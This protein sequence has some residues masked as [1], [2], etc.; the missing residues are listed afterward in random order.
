MESFSLAWR[1]LT[2]LP[3][4]RRPQPVSP[5]LG[6]SMAFFPTVGLLLG[7][8]LWGVFALFHLVFPQN[9]CA[10]LVVLLSALLTGA[11][12]LDGL[13]DTLDGLAFGRTAAERLQIMKDH[14]VGTFGVLGLVFAVVL[15]IV[16]LAAIPIDAV[17]RALLFAL[18]IGRWSMVLLLY[19]APYVRAEGVGLGFKD[20][21]GKKDLIWAAATAMLFGFILFP[22]W[23]IL[24]WLLAGLF[25][26]LIDLF[27]E[28]R[29]GGVTGD[30][31]GACNESNEVLAL[32]LVSAIA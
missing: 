24:L 14:R 3:W 28:N 25:T 1:F 13:A 21:L 29:I 12:H 27:F 16:V 11:L 23:G 22:I 18:V 20:T 26:L 6:R 2:I 30:V 31:L 4:I 15:K 7:L 32:I 10:G 9:A 17:G 8:L 19:R 5:V